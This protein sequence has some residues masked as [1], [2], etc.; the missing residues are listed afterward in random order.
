MKRPQW[1]LLTTNFYMNKP[2]S[3][4]QQAF[5]E[6]LNANGQGR[7]EEIAYTL[8]CNWGFVL[9]SFEGISKHR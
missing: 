4:P 3:Y 8:Q 6:R 9:S 5:I 1:F 7:A 2:Y